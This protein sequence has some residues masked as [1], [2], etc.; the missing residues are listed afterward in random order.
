M[1]HTLI[2]LPIILLACIAW[3]YVDSTKDLDANNDGRV[4]IV[5]VS[6]QIDTLNRTVEEAKKSE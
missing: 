6:I 5:D 4:D 2:L 1:K 3:A